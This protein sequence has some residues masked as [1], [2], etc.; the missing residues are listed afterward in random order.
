MSLFEYKQGQP[1]SLLHSDG[2]SLFE[3]TVVIVI[4]GI[5]LSVAVGR[6]L[7]YID[8]AE[9]IGVITT[10][11]QIRSALVMNAAQRIARGKAA[12]ISTLDGSNPMELMLETP[13]NYAGELT[14]DALLSAPARHWY[15]DLTARRLVYRPGRP[16]AWIDHKQDIENPE[17][18]V[19]VAFNDADG[20][21]TFEPG[22]DELHGVRLLRVAGFDWL[23]NGQQQ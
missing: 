10:E 9:R 12:S 4:I 18:A 7:P 21:G 22:R 16:M 13:A 8:E 3:L 1:E 14:G 2:F 23:G 6:L 17:F 15:F 19:R 11:S 20:N 5:L